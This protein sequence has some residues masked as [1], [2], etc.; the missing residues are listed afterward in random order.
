MIHSRQRGFTLIEL[1]VVISIIG[2]L[3]SLL[4]P[5]V[6]AA[7]EAGRRITC[8]NHLHNIGLAYQVYISSK[9]EQTGPGT[10]LVAAGW[11]GTLTPFLENQASTFL[12]PDDPQPT[13]SFD[14]P[15]VLKLTRYPGGEH[16][17]PCVP[18][19][20]QNCKIVSGTYG[21]FPFTLDFEWTGPNDTVG[22][23]DWNDDEITFTDAG[24]GLVK[25]VNSAVDNG[26]STGDGTFSGVLVD[27]NGNV[28]Y[29][30]GQWDGPGTTGPPFV[31]GEALTDYGINCLSANFLTGDSTKVLVL[32]YN[33]AVANVVAVTQL[34]TTLGSDT[35]V[36]LT[37]VAPRHDGTLNVLL[38][39]GSVTN[40][41]PQTID[42]T[43][44]ANRLRFWLP[45][46]FQK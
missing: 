4:L 46:I 8:V 11:T 10:G 32:E 1:L 12:C 25:A 14:N 36:Y 7:R 6:N 42:P 21:T 43:V 3:V 37:T 17:I 22:A 41:P 31:W 33:Q 27:G 23:R 26:G 20:A 29:S 30:F 13:S 18:N 44:A 34:G 45:G 28:I 15:P 24:D 35:D 38:G 39:D 9:A 2:I 16:D 5:A 40:Y 19:P